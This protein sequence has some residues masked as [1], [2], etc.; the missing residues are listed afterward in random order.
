MKHKRILLC[1]LGVLAM[2]AMQAQDPMFSQFYAAPLHINPAFAGVTFAP[3]LTLN[4]RNQWAQISGGYQ[5]YAASYEQ[6]LEALNSGFGI[7]LMADD[8]MDGVYKT[9]RFSG[10]YG[11]RL[12]IT[13][14][15]FVK[16]GVEAGMIRSTLDWDRLQFG[17][18]I[19]P[20]DG[21]EGPSG[22]PNQSAE[23]R[24]DNLNSTAVD[25]AAGLLIYNKN[26]YGG[27]SVK[28]INNPDDSFFEVNKN[29][30][31]GIPMRITLHGGAEFEVKGGNNRNAPAFI[32]PNVLVV[33]QGDFGQINVG[34]YAGFGQFFGG[35]YYRQGFSNA[36]AAMVLAGFRE[37]IL[38]IGYSYDFTISQLAS[39]NPGGTHEISLT[40]N[41]DD[42]KE[43]Q[44]RRRKSRYNDCFK[45]F[46]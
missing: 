27:V 3:R 30:G 16:F 21:F 35:V 7:I 4:Y 43:L 38:R 22:N 33:K 12:Q 8:A 42:S 26:F 2:W 40:I 29:L 20:I 34:A 1:A 13:N 25:I 17:D 19:D 6:P 37:G 45:M 24:P 41:F 23:Q 11:Y 32:S 9:N 28:H 31:A 14:E 18:Q 36:D 5:T 44:S 10:V 15:A 39:A 46:K